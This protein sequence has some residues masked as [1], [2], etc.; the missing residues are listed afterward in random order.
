MTDKE[1]VENKTR[2]VLD[3][4]AHHFFA[5]HLPASLPAAPVPELC[6]HRACAGV[7]DSSCVPFL[8]SQAFAA[9]TND[10]EETRG[11]THDKS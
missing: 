10:R 1:I 9:T 11:R 8:P 2:P 7:H 6:R 3:F 4:F 5:N